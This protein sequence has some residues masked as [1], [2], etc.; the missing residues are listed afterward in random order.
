MSGVEER[1]DLAGAQVLVVED[2]MLI[3]MLLE[4]ILEELGCRVV[5]SAV[6]LRQAE[7]LVRSATADAAILDVNLGGDPVFPVAEQLTARGIPFIFASGYGS[8]TLPERWQSTPTLPKP[9]TTDQVADT[10]RRVLR[11]RRTGSA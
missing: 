2:E 5:G 3:T 8:A 6:N 9:F 10:L 4:D 11:Q 7:D 1:D